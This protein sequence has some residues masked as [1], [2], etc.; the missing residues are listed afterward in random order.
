LKRLFGKCVNS[1]PAELTTFTSG[2]TGEAICLP[3]GAVVS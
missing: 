2:S 3:P 1:C